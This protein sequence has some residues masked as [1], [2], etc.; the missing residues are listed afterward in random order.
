MAE[1]VL[2]RKAT[3]E[4]PFCATLNRV[5]LGRALDRPKCGACGRP[6]LLDRPQA[7]S[8]DTLEQILRETEVPVVV[9]FYAD[10]C[11][12]CRV[13]APRLDEVARDRAGQVLVVK[14]DTDH[15]PVMAERYGIRGIPTLI[16][17]SVAR[18]TGRLVGIVARQQLDELIDSA[19][20]A[21]GVP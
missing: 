2:E 10:W 13:M 18:E 4:C 11:P 15:N 8:D 3:V 19:T 6:I 9:D 5:D 16:G 14:L 1:T 20:G 21:K 17:F 12:P 7:A